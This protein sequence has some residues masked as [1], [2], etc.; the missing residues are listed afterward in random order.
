MT[1]TSYDTIHL[2]QFAGKP[3]ISP[4]Y[5]IRIPIVIFLL[6][7]SA[8]CGV[9]YLAYQYEKTALQ[10]DKQAELL[11]IASNK[12]DEIS[13]WLSER[14]KDGEMIARN[15]FIGQAVHLWLSTGAAPDER[16]DQLL[17]WLNQL[18]DTFDYMAVLI[19]DNAGNV[20]LGAGDFGLHPK[21][22]ALVIEALQQGQ[23][24]MSDLHRRREASQGVIEIDMAVPLHLAASEKNR[25]IGALFFKID[26]KQYLFPLLQTWPTPSPSAET[27]LVRREGENLLFLNELRHR[28]N[29]ALT[30]RLPLH[31]KDLPTAMAIEQTTTATEGLDY[32]KVPVLAAS[33][34]VSR[35]SWYIVAKIDADEV[36]ASIRTLAFFVVIVVAILITWAGLGTGLWWRK[37]HARLLAEQYRGAVERQALIRHFDYLAKYANDIIL[38]ADAE[39]RLIEANARAVSAYGY[40]RETL[41][42]MSLKDLCDPTSQTCIADQLI[43]IG[44]S[45]GLVFEAIHRRK[46]GSSFPVEISARRFEIERK[47]FIQSIIRDITERKQAEQTLA[48]ERELLQR[49]LDN[50]PVMIVIYSAD[51]QAF[52]LN[53]ECERVLGWSTVTARQVDWLAAC[54][55]EP[56]YRAEVMQAMRTCRAG[57]RDLQVTA[58]DGSVVDS[59]WASIRLSDD[60]LV[61]IGIDIRARRRAEQALRR[62]HAWVTGILESITDGFVSLDHDWRYTYVNPTAARLLHQPA[63]ALLGQSLWAVCPPARG[64]VFERKFRRAVSE[65]QLVTFEGYYEPLGVWYECHCYPAPDGLSVFFT[66]TTERKRAEQALRESEARLRALVNAVP[67]VLLVLDEDGHY[68]EILT[69]EPHRLYTDPARLRGKTVQE[70]LPPPVAGQVMANIAETLRTRQ[71]QTLDYELAIASAGKRWY[72][73]RMAPLEVPL[74]GHRAVAVLARDVTQRRLTEDNLRQAQKMEAV[75]QLTG[76]VAHDFN[77]LLAIILGNLELLAEQLPAQASAQALLQPSLAAAER[78]AALVQR[79]LAFARRQPLQASVVELNTLV[80]NLLELLQRTLGETIQVQPQ[81]SDTPLYTAIDASQFETALLNLALN[82]RDA[83]PHGGT[84]TLATAGVELTAAD[85]VRHPALTPGPYVRLTV[86]DTGVGMAPSVLEHALEPFFTTKA[87]GKGSGLG[88]SMVYGLVTQSGGQ[89]HLDSTPGQGT[90]ITLYLPPAPNNTEVPNAVSP[91]KIATAHP[92]PATILV[93]E[94][95]PSVRQLAVRLLQSLG[96]TTV[97]A[98]DAEAALQVL[99]NTP[100]VTLLFSDVVLPGGRDGVALAREAR[101][102]R[103]ALKVLLTSGYTEQSLPPQDGTEPGFAFLSKPYHR[104]QL[105]SRLQALLGNGA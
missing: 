19:V 8:L 98:A 35:T 50:I 14:R 41:Q 96:Y 94:D 56:A 79:L 2:A 24:I 15:P 3:S 29:T 27:L 81:L 93:V 54:Y 39:G 4:W 36:Y 62:A 85:A 66:D 80:S 52:R 70:V 65:Q 9:S 43:H 58:R 74:M 89:L 18:R 28:Q 37:Q 38:L 76:G 10:Q 21:R 59:L 91:Q 31:D 97:T 53:A 72:E 101:R 92:T 32:R 34:P 49:I 69:A 100:A 45:D 95:D 7:A 90:T 33:Y 77:N 82:A 68:L 30:L 104:A 23:V 67:D 63:A 13:H 105:A 26:P 16:K 55:P 48:R 11:A 87:V 6:F 17:V 5:G 73:V 83:M 99:D 1:N 103:P 51:L 64:S 22:R 57:W 88:L 102:R 61:G 84:L 75:G 60:T 46:D 12:A 78:G 71:P 44:R 42:H 40:S 47:A 20:R 25:P 86:Q